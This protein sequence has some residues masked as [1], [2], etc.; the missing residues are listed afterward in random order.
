MNWY[1]HLENSLWNL[2]RASYPSFHSM[3]YQDQPPVSG[4]KKEGTQMQISS[5]ANLFKLNQYLVRL[6]SK[7]MNIC[8]I[9]YISILKCFNKTI[10]QNLYISTQI[11]DHMSIWPTIFCWLIYWAHGLIQYLVS[12]HQLSIALHKKFFQVG[13]TDLHRCTC[14]YRFFSTWAQVILHP[15]VGI[16]WHMFSVEVQA[17]DLILSPVGGFRLW[18]HHESF[19]Q[20]HENGVL[21]D[22]CFTCWCWRRLLLGPI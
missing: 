16:S 21:M 9:N 17:K 2:V 4:K 11:K 13:T 15:H 1:H 20:A 10:N 12:W 19:F 5:S 6:P 8:K 7:W 3:A 14:V 18:Q 22:S